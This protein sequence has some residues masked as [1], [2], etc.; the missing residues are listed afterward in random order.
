MSYIEIGKQEGAKVLADG[1]RNVLAGAL[2]GGYYVKP[3]VFEGHNH[4]RIFQEEIRPRGLSNNL[5]D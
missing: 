5:Q 2:A 4:M 1:E 3:T